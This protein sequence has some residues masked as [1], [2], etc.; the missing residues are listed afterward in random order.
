MFRLERPIAGSTTTARLNSR[1]TPYWQ[2][3]TW[4]RKPGLELDDDRTLVVIDLPGHRKPAI[5]SLYRQS[6]PLWQPG[7]PVSQVLD[8]YDYQAIAASQGV[9]RD[10]RFLQHDRFL[11]PISA[12]FGIRFVF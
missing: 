10:P 3:T 11:D 1:T 12:R 9:T 6:L 5:R 8:G 7:D 2:L 4:T